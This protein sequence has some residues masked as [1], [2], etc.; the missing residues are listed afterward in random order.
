MIAKIMFICFAVSVIAVGDN[1]VHYHYHMDGEQAPKV[2]HKGY[3]IC[4]AR[5][6]VA[7]YFCKSIT[8]GNSAKIDACKA[9]LAAKLAGCRV[10]NPIQSRRLTSSPKDNRSLSGSTQHKGYRTC[11]SWA[12]IR[13]P[14]CMTIAI[15][16]ADKRAACRATLADRLA[17]CRAEY[18]SPSRLLTTSGNNKRTLGGSRKHN[19]FRQTLCEWNSG[20]KYRACNVRAYFGGTDAEKA[21][22]RANC[23]SEHN[24]RKS[25]CVAKHSL[26]VIQK[27]ALTK[28]QHMLFCVTRAKHSWFW[29][30]FWAKLRGGDQK[31]S[32]IAECET[33]FNNANAACNAEA[34]P[35]AQVHPAA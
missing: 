20:I 27:R 2:S 11:Y 24:L 6:Y 21:Q 25:E 30:D 7:Y 28:E 16:S 15:F 35:P 33:K 23:E 10:E 4:A 12:Y 17:T 9:K 8:F 29:C 31:A 34:A 26:A 18:P 13:H 22:K 5:P 19:G 1:E 32:R 14:G 3:R